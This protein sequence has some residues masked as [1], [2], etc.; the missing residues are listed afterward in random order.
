M[1]GDCR[2]FCWDSGLAESD[3]KRLGMALFVQAGVVDPVVE[4][5]VELGV[6]VVEVD[7]ELLDVLL[8]GVGVAAVNR[9]KGLGGAAELDVVGGAFGFQGLGS[10]VTFSVPR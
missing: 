8:L 4:L 10:G 5:V 7:V 2:I 3:A 6:V 1:K 9:L